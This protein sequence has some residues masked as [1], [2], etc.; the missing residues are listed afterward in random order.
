L[1]VKLMSSKVVAGVMRGAIRFMPLAKPV[2][3]SG[4]RKLYA[5]SQQICLRAICATH[6]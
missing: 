1:L 3:E 5:R 2:R 6:R 4:A